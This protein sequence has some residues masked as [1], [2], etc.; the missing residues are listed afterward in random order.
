MNQDSSDDQQV[1]TDDD[2]KMGEEEHLNFESADEII[3]NGNV[4]EFKPRSTNGAEAYESLVK[5]LED[6]ETE[7]LHESESDS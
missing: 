6:D 4:D 5:S 2:M 1:K 3:V 7:F